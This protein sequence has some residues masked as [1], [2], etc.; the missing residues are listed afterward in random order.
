MKM[1]RLLKGTIGFLL[2]MALFIAPVTESAAAEFSVTEAKA[3]L[4]TNNDT[5]IFTDADIGTLV[6]SE[7]AS[8][9]PV[10]VTGITSNGYFRI[11]L[12]GQTFYI[13]GIGLSQKDT[14]KQSDNNTSSKQVYDIILAQK[15]VFP[16]GMHWTN[17]NYYEWK[18][19]TY[20]GGFGCAGF[21]FAVSDAAF[22]SAKAVVHK[23]YSNL[24]VGDILRVNDDTHSV[25]VLEVRPNSVIVAE[26]NYNS[27]IHWGREIP[28]A[29]IIDE[30]SYIMTRY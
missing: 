23:D 15:A 11:D 9:L 22:G 10:M 2:G 5:M 13:T 26:G 6:L 18:G 14:V 4:Y 29:E 21:A 16:E 8:D 25:V 30:S 27:S 28:K 3:V 12:G 1:K 24:K 19:G 17:D 7:V 20:T